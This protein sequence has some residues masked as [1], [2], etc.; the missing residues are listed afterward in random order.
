MNILQ[1][2]PTLLLTGILCILSLILFWLVLDSRRKWNLVFG[3]K[4]SGG[5]EDVTKDMLLRLGKIETELAA[6]APHTEFFDKA[7]R[8]SIQKIGF[9]RYNPF[10]NTGG[11]QSFS[12]ALLDH[13]NN[14][15]IISSL[16]LREGVRVYGKKIESGKASQ[17]LFD[18]EKEVL[19]EAIIKNS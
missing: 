6:L 14:G 11:D 18:E 8:S 4:K 5:T 9:K 19:E 15:V 13:E 3:K 7:T 2:N 17:T 12:M 1:N 16:Y 10:E